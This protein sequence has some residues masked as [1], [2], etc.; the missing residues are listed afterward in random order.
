MQYFM[1]LTAVGFFA[2]VLGGLLGIGGGIVIMPI[3]RLVVGLSPALAA[4]TCI[5]PVFFTSLGGSFR[6]YKLGHINFKSIVPVILSGVF[7]TVVF[8]IIFLY[9]TERQRWLDLGTG[10]VFSLVSLRMIVEGWAG[11]RGRRPEESEA[12]EV[13]GSLFGK[14]AIGGA[15]GVLPGFL[16]IGTGAVLVPA[17]ALILRAP[18]K[19]AIG[20]SLT[21]FCANAF[22]SSVFKSFQGFTVFQAAVPLCIGTLIG[23]NIGAVLNRRFP[24][25]VLKIMF[26]MVFSYVSFKYVV[27]FFG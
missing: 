16:G 14:L 4:G 23:S 2:G 19:V 9:F 13:K 8:S 6:H 1:M 26:G 10:L 15:A 7:A 18:I 21:C 22:L 27:L 24:S 17:F 20:S 11:L 25:A 12:S 5:V 3:L